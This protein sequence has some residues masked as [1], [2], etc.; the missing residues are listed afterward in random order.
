M[1][2]VHELVF[3]VLRQVCM[4]CCT[5]VWTKRLSQSQVFYACGITIRGTSE[6]VSICQKLENRRK[7]QV[8][9]KI[10]FDFMYQ[11]IL[12]ISYALSVVR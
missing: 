8:S 11:S 1:V 4:K 3:V 7:C 9:F 6:N 2:C 5:A 12:F 10:N